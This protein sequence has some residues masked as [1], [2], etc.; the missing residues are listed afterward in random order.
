MMEGQMKAGVV[1]TR[2]AIMPPPGVL[3]T[4]NGRGDVFPFKF[5]LLLGACLTGRSF[6][7]QM[8]VAFLAS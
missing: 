5:R 2:K 4:Q 6:L 7:Q 8:P 1:I 3:R